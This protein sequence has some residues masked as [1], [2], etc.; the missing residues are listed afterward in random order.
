MMPRIRRSESY[1]VGQKLATAEARAT[2]ADPL[3]SLLHSGTEPPISL[4]KGGTHS[5][6]RHDGKLADD[7]LLFGI[8]CAFSQKGRTIVAALELLQKEP[9]LMTGKARR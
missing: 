1:P 7:A 8:A 6:S 5:P 9:L 4:L 3:L 2:R